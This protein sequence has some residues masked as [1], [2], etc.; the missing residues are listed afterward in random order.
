M[1]EKLLTRSKYLT[2]AMHIIVASQDVM[3]P[4]YVEMSFSD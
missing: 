1:L 3:V 2:K 4:K